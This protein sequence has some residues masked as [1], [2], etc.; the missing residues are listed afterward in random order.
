LEHGQLRRALVRCDVLEL[1]ASAERAPRRMRV[2]PDALEGRLPIAGVAAES[3]EVRRQRQTL[4]CAREDGIVDGVEDVAWGDLADRPVPLRSNQER[5]E[6]EG[7][8]P[9]R[10][11]R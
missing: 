10:L 11:Q 2:I 3:S 7:V 5:V 9:Q 8:A 4:P 6:Q 1:H